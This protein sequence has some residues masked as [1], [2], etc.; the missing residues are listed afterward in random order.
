MGNSQSQE[1]DGKQ[2]KSA[3]SESDTDPSPTRR[4]SSILEIL[5]GGGTKHN[6]SS[7]LLKL[8]QKLELTADESHRHPGEL[9]KTTFE[10]AFHGPLSKFG[11]LLFKQMTCNN[12]SRDRERITKEQFTKAGKVLLKMFDEKEQH[13]YYFKLF[14]EGKEYL[15]KDDTLQMVNVS[16]ALTLSA[17][18][19][20]YI[21]NATDNKIFSGFVESMFGM[22]EKLSYEDFTTWTSKHSPHLFCGVHNWVYTILTGSKMPSEQ[23]TAPVPQLE[24]FVEGKHCMSIGMVWVLSTVIPQCYTHSDGDEKPSDST[25]GAKNPL[26]NSFNILMKLARL[27]RCQS[28][29]LLY[30]SRE[31]GLSKNRFSH[32]VLAYH[33][34]TITLVSFEGGNIYCVAE[35]RGWR[36]GNQRFGDKDTMLLQ[37]CPV[38]RVIQEGGPMVMWNDHSRDIKKGIHIGKPSSNLVLYIPSDFDTVDH[39]GVNCV[40]NDIEVWGCGSQQTAERQVKQKEW[41][42]KQAEKHATRKLRLD[43]GNWD[44][45]P[46][47]QILAW[48]GVNV[49]HQYSRDGGF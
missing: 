31:H 12:G 9:S 5:S 6:T 20:A 14:S 44:E 10:N 35:D 25:Q 43:T 34:P 22:K 37:I 36:E 26:L 45:N 27:T 39:Y 42:V 16:Y 46:D 18:N 2:S 4:K 33:G 15:T 24:K 29:T 28:W 38:F 1:P 11:K 3:S 30:D 49:E 32:H 21:K 7:C 8:F 23:E 13:K 40:L 17:S 41:E 48:G 19:I 47:K